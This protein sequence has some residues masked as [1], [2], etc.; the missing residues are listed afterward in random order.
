MVG[1]REMRITRMAFK[2]PATRLAAEKRGVDAYLERNW[3][4]YSTIYH[5][6]H[7]RLLTNMIEDLWLRVGSLIRL[8][9]PS[10]GH[11]TQSMQ[12]HWAATQAL[13]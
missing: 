9:I 13:T 2:E 7:N 1:L 10:P 8:T 11:F 6:T 4:R 12:Y 3:F 5:A